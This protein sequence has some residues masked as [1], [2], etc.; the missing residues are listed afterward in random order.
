MDSLLE[1]ALNA[2]ALRDAAMKDI[3][4]ITKMRDVPLGDEKGTVAEAFQ[5]QDVLRAMT[6]WHQQN[7]SEVLPT[8][9][10]CMLVAARE[11]C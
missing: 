10:L 2:A 5:A 1:S 9:L 6:E 8:A 3:E 11:V 4:E 7:E